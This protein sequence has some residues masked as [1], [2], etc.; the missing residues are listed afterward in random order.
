MPLDDSTY[1]PGDIH[2]ERLE[3]LKRVVLAAPEKYFDMCVWGYKPD[4]DDCGT[5]HCAM[6]WA[7]QDAYFKTDG[8]GMKWWAEDGGWSTDSPYA[9]VAVNG[10]TS[11]AE[12]FKKVIAEYFGIKRAQAHRLF[13]PH[14]FSRTKVTRKNFAR[15]VDA[16]IEARRKAVIAAMVSA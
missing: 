16:L 5:N 13:W 6:G 7:V 11:K 9:Y 4:N 10:C 12:N 14:E 15:Q 8:W 2:I 1:R 3:N